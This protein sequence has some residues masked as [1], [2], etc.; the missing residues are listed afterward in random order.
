MSELERIQDQYR[1]CFEGDAWHGP[2]V[3]QVLHDVDAD[4]AANK[5]LAGTHS[6][7]EIVLHLTSTHELVCRR[8]HTDTTPLSDEED[9]PPASDV[10]ERAWKS[11]LA[12]LEQSHQDVS[13]A[14][15]G[16]EEAGLDS[17]VIPEYSS[18]YVTVHGLIQHDLYHA[19]QIAMLKKLPVE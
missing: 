19:G 5:P 3:R 2:S 17:P 9:W 1:R 14:L 11:T 7:W 10:S 8:L 15:A 18:V 16:L 4:I 13:K 12:A 6:I